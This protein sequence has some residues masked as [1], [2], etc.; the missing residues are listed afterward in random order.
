MLERMRAV[1][2]RSEELD[3]LM[4][5]P[6]IAADYSRVQD[7]AKEQAQL[8]EVVELSRELRAIES[9]SDDLRMMLREESDPE[10]SELAREEL[11]ELETRWED[12]EQAL[13]LALV[14]KDP[15][16]DKN[17]I[18]EIRAGTGGD[19]AG[20]F[21]GDLYRMYSRYAQRRNWKTEVIDLN[22]TGIGS[23]KEI[24]FEVKGRGAYSRL[25]HESGVPQGTASAG[26]RVERQDTH[27]GG[28]R[29]G[30]AGGRRGGR[31]GQQ[32]RPPD[33][34]VPRIWAR[35]PER[36]EG[37]HRHPNHPQADRHRS[38]MPG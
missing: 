11:A 32:R 38:R 6:E 35:R 15:N 22:E 8:R 34:C 9:E 7:L 12:T 27:V 23:V 4:A 25:K 19:E 31:P 16:D 17:V 3:R 28:D 36:P 5:D 20:L 37:R 14:P 18:V 2:D 30:A 24:V 29:G 26:H 13:K 1:E 10:L 21:A 33:R